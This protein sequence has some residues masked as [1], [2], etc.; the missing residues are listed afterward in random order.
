MKMNRNV[1]VSFVI[2]CLL[3]ATLLIGC[4]VLVKASLD[5]IYVPTD[6][7][8]I[9]EAIDNAVSG[10]TIFVY[11]GIYYEQVIINKNVSLAGEDRD[12]TIIDGNGT[13]SVISITGV[14]NVGI[15]GFTIRRSGNSPSEYDS[16]IFIDHSNGNNISQ[17]T[18]TDNYHGINLQ[19]SF[20]NIISDNTITSNYDGISLQSSFN[21]IISDNTIKDNYNGIS[22]Q[23]SGNNLISD[24]AIT[25]NNYEGVSLYYSS[26]NIVSYNTIADNYE[27]MYLALYST[28]NAIYSNNFNDSLQVSLDSTNNIWDYGNEGNYW[29]DYEKRYPNAT[30]RENPGI[31]NTSYIIDN[32]NQDNYPLVG[33]FSYFSIDLERET[34]YITIICN[35]T[36]S[37]FKFE[38]GAETGNKIIQFNAKGKNGTIGFCR[39]RIPTE[40]MNYPYIV[41]VGVHE[42]APT[43]LPLSDE[44]YDY[45]YFTYIHSKDS[46]TIIS[47]KTLHLYYELLDKYDKLKNDLNDLNKTYHDL[48]NSHSNLQDNYSKLQEEYQEWNNSYQEHLSDYSLNVRNIRNLMYIVVAIAAI[49]IITTIYLSK[50]AHTSKTKIS[51]IKDSAR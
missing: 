2:L 28:N 16:G 49:F 5:V 45:L 43:L 15:E 42:T 32:H 31:W 46:I 41:L 10:D 40:L 4:K 1:L 30:E 34:Y 37:D 18:I 29:N 22:L 25:S 38:V 7:L 36:I 13:G 26:D 39:I 44:T 50:H 20:N 12:S 17:N 35:S 51:K 11:S 27:G 3:S 19:S 6:F 14:N 47:S 8:T 24:N 21:N 9:Q 48:L 33:M 23:S